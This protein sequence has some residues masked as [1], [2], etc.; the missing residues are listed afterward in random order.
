M[1]WERVDGV[2]GTVFLK[3][4]EPVNPNGLI[5][6]YEIKFHLSNEVRAGPSPR[7]G[8]CLSQ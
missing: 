7:P 3:W 5:L 2:E 1:T 4:P 6:M 8:T